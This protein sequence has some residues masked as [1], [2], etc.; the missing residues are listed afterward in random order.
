MA[1]ARADDSISQVNG[2]SAAGTDGQR[3]FQDLPI[4]PGSVR[5]SIAVFHL[6]RPLGLLRRGLT[7]QFCTDLVASSL[8]QTLLD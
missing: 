5:G 2:V 7:F 4:A 8:R 6:I 3:I 1:I